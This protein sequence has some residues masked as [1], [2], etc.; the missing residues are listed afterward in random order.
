MTLNKVTRKKM[1]NHHIL[2]RIIHEALRDG[3]F[4][5]VG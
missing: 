3:I 5:L 4:Q 1:L 2:T